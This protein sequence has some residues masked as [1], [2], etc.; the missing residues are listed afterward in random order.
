MQETHLNVFK[1][2]CFKGK[3]HTKTVSNDFLGPHVDEQDK[4]GDA[5]EEPDTSPEDPEEEDQSEDIL[6]CPWL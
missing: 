1:V 3:S 4:L 5:D 6:T 2:C